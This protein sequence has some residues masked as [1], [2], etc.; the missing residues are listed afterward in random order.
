[1]LKEAGL[2]YQKPRRSAAKADE[3]EQEA[4]HNEI[5]KATED[6]RHRSLY[7]PNQEIRPSRAACRVVSARHAALR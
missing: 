4:F 6:G 3:D 5:K 7:R 2:S 1:L